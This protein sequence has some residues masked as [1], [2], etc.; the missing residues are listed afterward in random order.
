[1][2]Y[3]PLDYSAIYDRMREAY[4]DKEPSEKCC[5]EPKVITNKALD[6]EFFVCQNCKQEVK[7][8]K[9]EV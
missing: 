6:K 7:N 9:G 4:N 2:S 5:E 1:M 8:E 3:Y